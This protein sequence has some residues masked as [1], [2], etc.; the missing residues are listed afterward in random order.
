MLENIDE[1][2]YFT[3]DTS[4]KMRLNVKKEICKTQLSL[5]YKKSYVYFK[6]IEQLLYF[7]QEKKNRIFENTFKRNI[8]GIS[9]ATEL[10]LQS[11]IKSA[12]EGLNA[13]GDPTSNC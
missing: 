4:F 11:C 5:E 13:L 1:I 12:L 2:S 6:I 3:T 9:K 7:I 10:K 8:G